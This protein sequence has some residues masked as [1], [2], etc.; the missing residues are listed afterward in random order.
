MF[1]EDSDQSPYGHDSSMIGGYRGIHYCSS[2]TAEAV[3]T[4]PQSM[5]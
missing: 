2:E 3:L 1:S 4:Y 5:F